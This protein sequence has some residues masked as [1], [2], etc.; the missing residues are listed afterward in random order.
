MV[1]DSIIQINLDHLNLQ[2]YI[3]SLFQLPMKR[4]DIPK[5]GK[6]LKL[7]YCIQA[8]YFLFQMISYKINEPPF[9]WIVAPVI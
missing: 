5:V 8:N 6:S 3:L 7:P 1:V 2:N 4:L 9:T